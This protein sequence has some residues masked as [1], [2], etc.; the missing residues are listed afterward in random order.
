MPKC[1]SVLHVLLPSYS[2]T[3]NRTVQCQQGMISTSSLRHSDTIR[4][5]T[6]GQTDE[7]EPNPLT[8]T[9]GKAR[10]SYVL[11]EKRG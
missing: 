7:R 11:S 1:L 2:Q 6:S 9:S 3:P 8:E 10:L 5:G 4:Q